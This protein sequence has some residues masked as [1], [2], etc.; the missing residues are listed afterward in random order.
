MGWGRY[1]GFAELSAN[2]RLYCDK[3]TSNEVMSDELTY[4]TDEEL[5]NVSEERGFVASGTGQRR[6]CWE[7]RIKG[8]W[9]GFGRNPMAQNEPAWVCICLRGAG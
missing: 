3:M 7:I 6:G 2:P 1:R 4:D 5:A 9:G 8:G